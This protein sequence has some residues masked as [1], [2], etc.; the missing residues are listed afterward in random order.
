MVIGATAGAANKLAIMLIGD[1]YPAIAT[2]T[3]AQK[4]IAAIG[5]AIACANNF[6]S[7]LSKK[8]MMRG[9]NSNKPAVASTDKAKPASRLC[10][11]SPITTA[12]IAKPKAGKESAP[13][14]VA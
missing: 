7:A 3:G 9:A 5:G 4:T 12:A 2:I 11:G 8:V 13:R 14:F 10:Q 6:G 1:R